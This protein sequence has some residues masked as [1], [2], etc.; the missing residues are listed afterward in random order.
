MRETQ[1]RVSET[2]EGVN[3][4]AKFVLPVN[5]EVSSKG[6]LDANMQTS[7]VD[8]EAAKDFWKIKL[9]DV[10]QNTQNIMDVLKNLRERESVGD[11]LDR[12]VGVEGERKRGERH[13][14]TTGF[15]RREVNA[16]V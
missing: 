10:D 16:G 15:R 12:D 6:N 3:L 1:I 14:G 11:R 7:K 9:D 4:S 2:V 8:L 13:F 5:V